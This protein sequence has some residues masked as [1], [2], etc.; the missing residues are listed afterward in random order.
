MKEPE[1]V[2]ACCAAIIKGA[3]AA[4]AEAGVAPPEVTVKCRLGVDSRDSYEELIQFIKTVSAAGVQHFIV[5]ARKALLNLSTTQNRSIPPLRHDWVF[6]LVRDFPH[7]T[8]TLNGGVGTVEEVAELLKHGVAG[9]M[10]GRRANADPYNLFSRCGVLFSGEAGPSRREVLDK[11]LE[12]AA[13]AQAAN[14]EGATLEQCA[15]TIIIPLTGLMHNTPFGPRWRQA[16]TRFCQERSLLQQPGS[17]VQIVRQCVAEVALPDWL[18]DERPS[19]KLQRPLPKAQNEPGGDHRKKKDGASESQALAAPGSSELL[20][21]QW[22]EAKQANDFAKADEVRLDLRKLGIEPNWNLCKQV[23]AVQS[24]ANA[25]SEAALLKQQDGEACCGASRKREGKGDDIM[26]AIFDGE[27][28]E[29]DRKAF[30]RRA[31]AMA[32]VVAAVASV[33][34]LRARTLKVR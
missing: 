24:A 33:W 18:L 31:I 17:A 23:E 32:T 2:A 16:L 7:L 29:R 3:A 21:R 10:I 9:V 12:Y 14:W 15:R 34:L 20:L 1:R 11:Y 25:N 4:A 5:H 8:F 22:M 13:L 19:L 26:D 6:Q 27:A 28:Q 30:R